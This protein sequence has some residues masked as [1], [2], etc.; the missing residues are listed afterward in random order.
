MAALLA[1]AAIVTA[2]GSAGAQWGGDSAVEQ[3]ELPPPAPPPDDSGRSA[4]AAPQ[5]GFSPFPVDPDPAPEDGWAD[6]MGPDA[7][8]LSAP[9]PGER[10]DDWN[11]QE[12][13]EPDAPQEQPAEPAR[14]NAQPTPLPDGLWRG[15]HGDE[16]A[17]VLRNVALPSPSPALNRLI[18]AALSQPLDGEAATA[19]QIAA[20]EKAGA[21]EALAALRGAGDAVALL[22]AGRDREACAA[23]AAPRG[24]DP[25]ALVVAAWCAAADKQFDAAMLSLDLAREAGA[26]VE[27]ASASI[28][29]ARGEGK[30][31][32]PKEIGA[33]EAAFLALTDG[34]GE[35]AVARSAPLGLARLARHPGLDPE[36][37]IAAAERAAALNIVDG[38]VLA[39]AYRAATGGDSPGARRAALFRAAEQAGGDGARA[40][41][42]AGLFDSVGEGLLDVAFAQALGPAVARIA[43]SPELSGFAETGL[44]IAM[45]SGDFA[46]AAGWA[47]LAVSPGA[48]RWRTLLAAAAPDPQSAQGGLDTATDLA[49]SG[50][51]P[52]E[53][54]HRLV[55]VLDALDRDVPIP[56]WEKASASPQPSDG[57]LPKTGVLT[58][59][60]ETAEQ[61]ETGLAIL[62]AAVALGPKGPAE[63]NLIALG[64][65]VR[66]LSQ[67]GLR[68]HAQGVALDALYPLWLASDRAALR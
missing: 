14:R 21:A 22:A 31:P 48:Q 50:R 63:A 29:A 54:M 52:A 13:S 5:D 35:G 59:L 68:D 6:D 1:V 40:Q 25:E 24:G 33:L 41:A 65:A 2:A 15:A 44:R 8:S 57:H 11:A 16:I 7:P 3:R 34:V 49:T 10:L 64:D 27:F 61:R 67:L 45:L 4:P 36:L 17:S 12:F 66:A 39:A 38:Q 19:A 62:L 30:A 26:E 23:A 56:L 46:A 42:A 53:M 55:T 9:A 20:L 47:Q 18:V 28:T 32:A 37:R 43:P 51:L 58:A 60:K